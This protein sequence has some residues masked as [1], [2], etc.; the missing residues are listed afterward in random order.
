[1]CFMCLKDDIFGA[2]DPSDHQR[3]RERAAKVK[4]LLREADERKN[5]TCYVG[6]A[7]VGLLKEEQYALARQ[8]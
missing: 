4:Q 6:D 7:A 2:K 1:M 3:L 5:E 8:L